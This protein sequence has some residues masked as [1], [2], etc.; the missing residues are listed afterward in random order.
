MHLI[1]VMLKRK[2]SC[3]QRMETAMQE[4]NQA[5]LNLNI[6]VHNATMPPPDETVFNLSKKFPHRLRKD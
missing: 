4:L 5:I 1:D 6:S 3:K 2:P